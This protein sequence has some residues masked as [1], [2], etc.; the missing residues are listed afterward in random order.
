MIDAQNSGGLILKGWIPPRLV[1][2]LNDRQLTFLIGGVTQYAIDPSFRELSHESHREVT[3]LRGALPD[4]ESFS[5]RGRNSKFDDDSIPFR[6]GVLKV[7]SN[8]VAYK[9]LHGPMPLIERCR[10]QANGCGIGVGDR[11]PAEPFSPDHPGHLIVS[12]I[13]YSTN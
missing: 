9:L 2:E 4:E 5:S 6:P 1:Q 13:L 3:Y 10:S 12:P 7:G 8:D 11:D